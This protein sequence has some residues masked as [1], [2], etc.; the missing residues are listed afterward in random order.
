MFLPYSKVKQFYVYIS[1]L[2]FS[3]GFLGGTVVK[4]LPANAGDSENSDLIPGSG[5]SPG[6]GH[7]NPLQYSEFHAQS[8]LERYSPRG[9]KESD[10]NEVA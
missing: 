6:A 2:F 9:H 5:R 4:N 3:K 8:S 7:G 1:P 10:R